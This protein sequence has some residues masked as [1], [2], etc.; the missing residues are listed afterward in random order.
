MNEWRKSSL[1]SDNACVE[2][3]LGT[4]VGVRDTK[5]P[6]GRALWFPS[7][8]WEKF[9]DSATVGKFDLTE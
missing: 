7:E 6:E 5:D 8:V 9:I 4:Q 2:V 3:N 1:C